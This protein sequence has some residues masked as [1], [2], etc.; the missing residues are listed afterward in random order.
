MNSLQK[1]I[2]VG[3]VV[4]GFLLIS[5]IVYYNRRKIIEQFDATVN[6][7]HNTNTTSTPA[8]NKEMLKL[9]QIADKQNKDSTFDNNLDETHSKKV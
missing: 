3:I 8:D 5:F 1:F 9:A 6:E 7:F 2:Y 4:V